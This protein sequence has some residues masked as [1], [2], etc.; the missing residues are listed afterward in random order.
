MPVNYQQIQNQIRQM[1]AQAGPREELLRQQREQ[2][3][4]L[5]DR[6]A[7]E[8]EFLKQ[9]VER[10]AAVNPHLRC[11]VPLEERLD[12]RVP[13][14]QS[15]LQ[16]VL[17][18]A[19][20][21]QIQPNRHDP[22]EFGV[23]NVGA[24]RITPGSPETPREFTH[25][26][27]LYG[28]KLPRGAGLNREELIALQRDLEER[29][30]LAELAYGEAADRA[31]ITLTDGPL[32][33]LR[34]PA[35]LPEYREVLDKYRKVLLDLAQRQVATAGYVDKPGSN[36]VVQLLELAD[37]PEEQLSGE[38]KNHPLDGVS[39][40]DLFWDLL[41]SGERSAVFAIQSPSAAQ[42]SGP[43][44]VHFFYLNVSAGG[45]SALA[46]VEIPAWVAQN[47]LIVAELHAVLVQQARQMGLHPYPY[48]LHRAHEIALV[49][50]Q[51]KDQILDS[52]I[53][54]YRR[55]GIPVGD[56]SQKQYAKDQLGAKTRYNR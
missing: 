17:L 26:S 41:K 18:A 22:V 5:L 47:P 14:P 42:F 27:L 50:F 33:L 3:H 2:A 52:I 15:S 37:L 51:E 35:D 24:I 9:R 12:L 38:L 34:A 1:G 25:S 28:D 20:G 7:G 45:H 23:I 39:D 10:A 32:E 44:Q 40:A 31:V 8:L 29:S 11:A 56:K 13:V 30:T 48:A 53:R 46:R 36:L 4:A 21:S 49:T 19:D 55:L 54:E 6:F 43:L 16:P